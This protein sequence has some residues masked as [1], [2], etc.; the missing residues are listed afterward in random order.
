MPSE[1]PPSHPS[2]SSRPELPEGI[3]REPDSDVERRNGRP[4]QRERDRLPAWPAWTPIPALLLAFL[5]AMVGMLLIVVGVELTGREV[6]SGDLPPG[7]IISATYVQD[8]ALVV[9]AILFARIWAGGVS[10]ADF[11]LRRTSLKSAIGWTAL[12]WAAFIAFSAAWAAALGIT[13]SDDLPA[14]LGAD[15][16]TAAM[17]AV[18]ILVTLLAPFS[19]ELFFRGF[20]F[21][22]VRRS[23]GV[24]IGAVATGVLFGVIH[25]GGT[26]AHFL[27]PLGVLGALLCLLYWRTGSILPCIVLHAVNNSIALGVAL[28][29]SP[30]V[31]VATV[32]GSSAVLLAVSLPL[33]APART[34]GAA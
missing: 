31:V 7:V 16:S 10:P 14:Q 22:A 4:E 13:D 11:G 21:T 19:E 32:I 28:S 12:T 6:D 34:A 8:I 3:T 18:T 27:V 25:A 5:A 1:P 23:F 33:A 30:A 29:W 17:I 15:E 20:C 9:S 26:E 2:L 24:V